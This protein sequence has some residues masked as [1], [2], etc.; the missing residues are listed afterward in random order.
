VQHVLDRL[1]AGEAVRPVHPG[2]LAG[3]VVGVRL[4]RRDHDAR[5]PQHLGDELAVALRDLRLA[6]RAH[7][8]QGVRGQRSPPEEEEAACAA[9][10][11]LGE[12]CGVRHLVEAVGLAAHADQRLVEIEAGGLIA[13]GREEERGDDGEDEHSEGDHVGRVAELEVHDAEYELD[14]QLHS[15]Q[16]EEE[17]GPRGPG[18]GRP[19]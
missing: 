5:P 14:R 9:A 3:R 16:T 7:A 6:V 2:E 17:A 19:E 1:V 12:E 15:H 10:V 8:D 18:R 4:R 13:R 11:R